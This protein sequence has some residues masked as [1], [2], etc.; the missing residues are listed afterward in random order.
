M[1]VCSR[2][3]GTG[4]SSCKQGRAGGNEISSYPCDKLSRTLYVCAIIIIIIIEEEDV[5]L[6]ANEGGETKNQRSLV[7]TA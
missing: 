3:G 1:C 4:K 2:G 6:C 7:S 5:T